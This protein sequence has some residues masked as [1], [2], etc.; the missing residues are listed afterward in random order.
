MRYPPGGR[1]FYERLFGIVKS[2]LK[3]ILDKAKV[4]Y[5]EMCTIIFEAKVAK[6]NI[7]NRP[8]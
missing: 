3:E 5:V 2:S 7:N 6:G 4:P 8:Q 1:R